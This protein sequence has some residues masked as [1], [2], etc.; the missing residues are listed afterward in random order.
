MIRAFLNL[1]LLALFTLHISSAQAEDVSSVYLER[2]EIEAQDGSGFSAY[3]LAKA[4]EK[5]EDYAKAE[6]WYRFAFYK[7]NG[8]AA[9]N[10][11]FLYKK[12]FIKLEGAETVK[13][14]G[15]DMIT[16]E[17]SQGDGSAALYLAVVYMR[18]ELTE[19]NYD[20]SYEWF[21]KAHED[22][23]PMA[24]YHLGMIYL[25]GLFKNT[26]HRKALRYFEKASIGGVERATRQLA[27]SYHTGI[28]HDQNLG[29]AITL[30]ERA[31]A[32]GSVLAMRD[33]A[34]IYRDERPNTRKYLFWL[35]KAAKFE[36]PDA[37]YYLGVYYKGRDKKKSDQHFKKAAS[38]E[39]HLARKE[40]D[41]S[42]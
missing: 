17:A 36:D 1:L 6:Q 12:G 3:E 8:R 29:K 25:N 9:L 41:K 28:L 38:L 30:Y 19:K 18:G 24:S 13:N 33:L 5:L 14:F 26:S 27:L 10:L 16:A 37:H 40:S 35:N 31:A 39:H 15:I 11:Y 2:L 23:K 20:Q 42:Y 32:Q 22:G 7:N 4:Y 34:N 21:L